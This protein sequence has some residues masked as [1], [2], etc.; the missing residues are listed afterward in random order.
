[1]TSKFV[2]WWKKKWKDILPV[3]SKCFR[4]PLPKNKWR[5]AQM[6]YMYPKWKT[7]CY[8]GDKSITN[9]SIYLV[10]NRLPWFFFFD[11]V[12]L[13][14]FYLKWE[15]ASRLKLTFLQMCACKCQ[16]RLVLHVRTWIKYYC[17]LNMR[18]RGQCFPVA[19]N[20]PPKYGSASKRPEVCWGSPHVCTV[21]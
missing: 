3:S 4:P 16:K 9:I 14:F 19:R 8:L 17:L 12:V 21:E 13:Y 15:K 7:E 5:D 18:T 11:V 20:A 1:M 2:V 10:L 6:I